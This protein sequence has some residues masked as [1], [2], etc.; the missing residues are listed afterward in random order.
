MSSNRQLTVG[1]IVTITKGKKHTVS[2]SPSTFSKRII[3]IDDLRN[4]R[5]IRFTDDV[6][7]TEVNSSDVMIA[8]DGANAGTIGFG[9][10]GF[11]GSTIARLRIN[12][13]DKINTQFVGYFLKSQFEYLR[14]TSTGATIPHINRRALEKISFPSIDI[15][16]QVRI[17]QLLGR[18]ENIIAERIERKNQLDNLVNSVFFEMFGDPV[19]NEKLWNKLPLGDLLS[20]IDSGWSPKC[21]SVSANDDQWGVLKLGA[22]TS[23]AFKQE[24][25]KA[26]LPNSEPKIQHEVKNGDLLFSRKNTYELVAATAFVHETRS[27]LLLPDLIFRL[28]IKDEGEIHPVY[29]WK[30]L[31][32]PSQRKKI[33]SLAAGA[34][35]S[36]PNIS[37]A[38]LKTALLPV[39]SIE[40]Q[41]KFVEI[42]NKIEAIKN[43]FQ[44][45]LNDLELLYGSLSQKAFKGELDLSAVPLPEY[46][47]EKA[48]QDEDV[49]NELLAINQIQKKL[50][51]ITKPLES[52]TKPLEQIKSI[53]RP[54]E[55]ITKSL[56]AIILPK[57]MPD[58]SKDKT[59]R[60]W[61][62][63]LLKEFLMDSDTNSFS[64][65]D[66]WEAAQNWIGKFE[67]E[68]CE[69]LCFSINDYEVLKDW[70]FKKLRT[71]MILQ[72]Y[73]EASN[74]IKF[75]V[76]QK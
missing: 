41:L 3:L 57:V 61:L 39:P 58:L 6:K 63:K 22:V 27:K 56:E 40:L 5:T 55:Q 11:L 28:V 71:G 75:K 29:L 32:Y 21:E 7:G 23:G 45:S 12:E 49:E 20:Q 8:W 14:E 43:L 47:N 74:S 54:I 67:Q 76:S 18:I 66:F 52:L 51:R 44:N 25:N 38:N 64:L 46:L 26:M 4:D 60:K 59:R 24:E 65:P 13:L 17:S 19:H 37:K 9:K 30:L 70:L 16:E 48:D 73:Q 53:T 42:S 36:M 72:V 50:E 1:D 69:S 34:A 15:H 68:D 10:S 2:E 35:G 62:I 31:S 33:Q